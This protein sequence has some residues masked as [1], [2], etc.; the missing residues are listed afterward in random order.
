MNTSTRVVRLLSTGISV[1]GT[2]VVLGLQ[3]SAGHAD[4]V[5]PVASSTA[6]E[7]ALPPEVVRASSVAKTTFEWIPDERPPLPLAE[8]EAGC[9]SLIDLLPPSEDEL[10]AAVLLR[11]ATLRLWQGKNAGYLTDISQ[12]F[13]LCPKD[14]AIRF[15]YAQRFAVN[16]D[17]SSEAERESQ[18]LIADFPDR[19]EGY[20]VRA[21]LHFGDR[22]FEG[23]VAD[24]T[25]ALALAPTNVRARLLRASAHRQLLQWQECHDD[26][27]AALS[28][29]PTFDQY[30][31]QVW[32]VYGMSL[33]ALDRSNDAI[34]VLQ[35]GL[36]MRPESPSIRDV[37]W[38]C[39]QD[40][41]RPA[42]CMWIATEA[43]RAFPDSARAHCE[44]AL[45]E[46]HYGYVDLALKRTYAA[47]TQHPKDA[48]VLETLGRILLRKR[49]LSDAVE[50]YRY[51][52]Q[53]GGEGCRDP[54][55][56]LAFI[57]STA[58]DPALRNREEAE[59]FFAEAT[60]P[61]RL[62]RDHSVNLVHACLLADRGAF[63]EASELLQG[64][65]S[66]MPS[67]DMSRDSATKL[68]EL[69]G[70]QQPYRLTGDAAA[71]AFDLP[72][73]YW[74]YPDIASMRD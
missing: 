27:V 9:T 68:K 5:L 34:P 67:D 24:T 2:A 6:H 41:R 62:P 14:L 18:A 8:M 45:S 25:E 33:I 69:F 11:R 15:L 42:S 63:R 65:L 22:E 4:D 38:F 48:F 20:I 60:A 64:V 73:L 56:H 53:F 28:C 71:D 39:Y 7:R 51:A 43:V 1:L 54:R 57:L 32:N 70:R 59:R 35:R 3:Q 47:A 16:D 44:L 10:R 40:R 13:A 50:V 17:L 21:L 26:A 23:C 19:P 36:A 31:D 72:V 37:L 46:A 30:F 66:Q 74:T 12:A 49:Q 55:L 61:G 29:P 58:G 52:V